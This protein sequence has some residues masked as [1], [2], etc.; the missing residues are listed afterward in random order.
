MLFKDKKC[1]VTG[2]AG[3][4]GSNVVVRL[5]ELGAKVC[6]LDSMADGLGGNLFNLE[7]V[8][9][10]IEFHGADQRDAGLLEKLVPGQDY[11]FNLTGN[12]SH[13]DSMRHPFFD[14]DCNVAAQLTLLEA[15]RRFNKDAVV[16]YSSTRQLY[17]VP[18]YLPVDEAHPITPV[19]V[20]GIHKFA[21]DQYHMLYSR[22]HGIRTVTLRLT[23]TYGPRQL[24]RHARQGF[25]GW[26]V[27]RAITDS[28]IQLYGTGKQ[29]RD[30]NHVRDVVEAMLLAAVSPEC[31]GG[32]FNLSGERADLQTVAELL[33]KLA[34]K[35]R[36]ERVEF[37]AEAKK[38]EIGD[39]YG[40][41][42]KFKKA[43]GWEPK[44]G[45]EQ[46][47]R[48]MVDFFKSNERHYR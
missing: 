3:F 47:L 25:I 18:K 8:R 33:V 17:G 30:F 46:G 27:N 28:V 38:I 35:G 1:L 22:V 37:P 14:L 36:I 48:E 34:G 23:N 4:I 20:N 10:R 13:Q 45:L 26:F 6:V 9:D 44:T 7:S 40:T 41:S 42:A 21:G 5:V 39:F 12:V 32:V 15:C 43:C 31:F 2:G 16:V 29:V 19:D 11:I 24:I